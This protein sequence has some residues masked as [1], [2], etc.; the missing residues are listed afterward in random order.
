M[1]ALIVSTGDAEEE[2]D[3]Y[4]SRLLDMTEPWDAD[5]LRREVRR[6]EKES[7]WKRVVRILNVFLCEVYWGEEVKV[8]IEVEDR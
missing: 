2:F 4:E 5:D 7:E 8:E 1:I 3:A 6:L